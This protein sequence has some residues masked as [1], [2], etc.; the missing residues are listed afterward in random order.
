MELKKFYY[1][2]SSTFAGVQDTL[3]FNS[4]DRIESQFPFGTLP[5][6]WSYQ[7]MC[8]LIHAASVANIIQRLK[9]A[10][11]SKPD[12]TY[13][14]QILWGEAIDVPASIARYLLSEILEDKNQQS[15][16]SSSSDAQ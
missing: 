6:L 16:S 8:S 13:I 4:K 7:G 2:D 15:N 1:I 12:S 10:K 11:K 9:D 5:I 14:I 3:Y